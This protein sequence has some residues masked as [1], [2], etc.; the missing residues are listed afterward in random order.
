MQFLLGSIIHL[1]CTTFSN[2]NYITIIYNKSWWSNHL[3]ESSPSVPV[4]AFPVPSSNPWLLSWTIGNFLPSVK[5]KSTKI[6]QMANRVS[7]NTHKKLT[8]SMATT[9]RQNRVITN[10]AQTVTT[11]TNMLRKLSI[12]T[13]PI[14]IISIMNITRHPNISMDPTA[15]ITTII[16]T[17]TNTMPLKLNSAN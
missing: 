9:I 2:S 11:N 14:A 12:S 5:T 7:I 16:V 15:L 1:S 8:V 17:T 4:L 3:S 10:M 6:T 13:D